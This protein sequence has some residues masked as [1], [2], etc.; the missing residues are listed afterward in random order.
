MLLVRCAI[1][2]DAY[3]RPPRNRGKPDSGRLT[4]SV[5]YDVN[6]IFLPSLGI[7]RISF[8]RIRL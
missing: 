1:I 8:H 4:C 5:Y 6:T 2:L 7:A 3:V